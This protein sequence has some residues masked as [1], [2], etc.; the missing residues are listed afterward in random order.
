[1]TNRIRMYRTARL[2]LVAGL[3]T[4]TATLGSAQG[5]RCTTLTGSYAFSFSG[6]TPNP[7]PPA[8]MAPYNGVGIATFDGAGKITAT[9][10]VNFGG[11]VLRNAPFSGTYTLNPDCTGTLTVKFPDGSIGHNDYV[12]AD[13]GKTLLAIST[14]ALPPGASLSLTFTKIPLT[15]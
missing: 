13:G 11:F 6:T 10:S 15:W 5:P 14:D 3:L 9:E 8:M 4:L 7:G 2:A 12:V 1:M